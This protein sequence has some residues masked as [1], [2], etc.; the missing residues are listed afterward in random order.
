MK[1][2]M[3][4]SKN[5]LI[6]SIVALLEC[7][8]LLAITT[9]SWIESASSLKIATSQPVTI[10]ESL[11]YEYVINTNSNKAV[12]L[13]TYFSDT[14]YFSF[15]QASSADGK[16]LFFS[17]TDANGN[18]V[19]RAGNTTD[20]N[21]CFYN[22][23]FLVNNTGDSDSVLYFFNSEDIFAFVDDDINLS[24]GTAVTSE[25][26]D[27]FLGAFRIAI[28]SGTAT[29]I[30]SKS[31]A[32]YLAASSTTETREL[33]TK[34]YSSHLYN[35]NDD[36]TTKQSKKIFQCA[37]NST[38]NINIKIWF[39]C[40]DTNFVDLKDDVKSAL[41]GA[42]VKINLVFNN[43][44]SSFK[45][46]RFNDYTNSILDDDTSG[47]TMY[48]Y[49]GAV[50]YPMTKVAEQTNSDYIEW[51]TCNEKGNVWSTISDEIVI[52]LN[53]NDN[54][55]YF[56]YGTVDSNGAPD[57][58]YTWNVPSVTT[59][60]NSFTYNA[61]SIT[62]TSANNTFTGVGYWDSTPIKAVQFVDKT[63][64]S[65]N[66]NYNASAYQFVSE[67]RLY[68]GKSG[69]T[70]TPI[71][72]SLV[73]SD[74]KIYKAYV[75]KADLTDNKTYFYYTSDAYY[76]SNVK[77]TWKA[78]AYKP[79]NTTQSQTVTE[80]ES[81]TVAETDYIYTALGYNAYGRV[82]SLN[83]SVDGVGLW[84]DDET[85]VKKI[86]LSTEL[87]DS[88]VLANPGYKFRVGYNLSGYDDPVY[89]YM[90]S[91]SSDPLTYFAYI[92]S[93]TTG[94]WFECCSTFAAQDKLSE[95]STTCDT[96]S[97]TYYAT[98]FA[99]TEATG[100]WNPVV[101]VDGTADNLIADTLADKAKTGAS[102][103]YTTNSDSDSDMTQIDNYRW[104]TDTE[105]YG[106]SQIKF[107]WTA[108]TADKGYVDTVFD[109]TYELGKSSSG[110]R[111][112]VVT[113]AGSNIKNTTDN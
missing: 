4:K 60:Y 35:I 74:N 58:D 46:F 96:N 70:S 68:V 78:P 51:A 92:P 11:N 67:N 21:N 5:N 49:D 41:L 94:I 105:I 43:A 30:Y 26:M 56:Y 16:S 111:Y 90:A 98:I 61:L 99:D 112:Y 88:T 47:K 10:A 45:T 83:K 13:S 24:D 72:M 44:E 55:C 79:S 8:L 23:D 107:K 110:I 54:G 109:Y 25:Q 53:S 50:A 29:S 62:P 63:T 28:T 104:V 12:D 65:L 100:L 77:V 37:G 42:D 64:Q 71:K 48:F 103:T 76:A 66:V 113:E 32:T 2:K 102:L 80:T 87:I 95:W 91:E 3:L 38:A 93:N 22:F 33:T 18:T 7:V 40:N 34:K 86:Y 81:A 1:N 52:K 59:D 85:T 75:P 36:D 57:A 20:Y 6:I 101:L 27:S 97:N 19:Y 69:D 84:V 9:Y 82:N 31:S 73:D 106:V 89:T 108:Y 39:E 15:A 17:R 14:A